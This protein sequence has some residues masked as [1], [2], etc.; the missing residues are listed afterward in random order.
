MARNIRLLAALFFAAGTLIG[1]QASGAQIEC[2]NWA[3]A[4]SIIARYGL[5][6]AQDI[7]RDVRL[8]GGKSIRLKL[9]KRDNEFIYIMSILGP[10]GRVRNETRNA[11]D[12]EPRASRSGKNFDS[13]LATTIPR[14][15]KKCR[16]SSG[17]RKYLPDFLLR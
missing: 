11:H 3:E 1:D 12:R 4:Q 17:F 8:D 15:R 14:F 13:N 2:Y 9:C 10:R 7:N 6:P 16:P 5:V